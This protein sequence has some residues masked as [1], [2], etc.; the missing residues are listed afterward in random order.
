MFKTTF[1]GNIGKEPELRNAGNYQV[2][3]FNVAVRGSRKDKESGEYPTEWITV[4]IWGSR[5][6]SLASF[7]SK[8]TKVAVTGSMNVRRFVKKNGE[9][10]FAFEVDC[11][12]LEC[13][14]PRSENAKPN[15]QNS[16]GGF[17]EVDDD[18]LPF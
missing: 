9:P 15:E 16:T 5:A 10:A 11:D 7:L 1:I 3:Q 14:T 4:H 18:E 12:D 13:L 2:L 6:N 8:G 17:T